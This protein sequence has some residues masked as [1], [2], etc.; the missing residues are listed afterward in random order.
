MSQPD[1]RLPQQQ[2]QQPQNQTNEPI[3]PPAIVEASGLSKV[4]WFLGGFLLGLIGVFI[5]YIMNLGRPRPVRGLVIRYALIGMVA[6]ALFSMIVLGL[7]GFSTGT[8]LI[9]PMAGGTGTSTS[10]GSGIF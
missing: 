1:V 9:G 4:V 7:G 6:G 5:L 10:T 2:P 8:G 3:Q